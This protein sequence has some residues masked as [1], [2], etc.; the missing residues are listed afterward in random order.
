MARMDLGDCD[1][2]F[3][4]NKDQVNQK[5]D[6]IK[7]TF[8]VMHDSLCEKH[9]QLVHLDFINFDDD[10][11]SI[12]ISV[13]SSW[14]NNALFVFFLFQNDVRLIEK[15]GFGKHPPRLYDDITSECKEDLFRFTNEFLKKI[16]GGWEANWQVFTDGMYWSCALEVNANLDGEFPTSDYYE[17]SYEDFGFC[18]NCDGKL[19]EDEADDDGFCYDCSK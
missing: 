11:K 4:Y 9:E 5:Y 13:S 15:P 8:S 10:K 17:V 12:E 19:G 7:Q 6:E 14:Y 16:D 3:G 18:S 1:F 2:I